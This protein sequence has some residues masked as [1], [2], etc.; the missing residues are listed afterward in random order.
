MAS[1]AGTRASTCTGSP[2]PAQQPVQQQQQQDRRRALRRSRCGSPLT[3]SHRRKRLGCSAWGKQGASAGVQ[4]GQEEQGS[5][6]HEG[7]GTSLPQLGAAHAQFCQLALAQLS[8]CNTNAGK[9]IEA[10]G[11]QHATCQAG[12]PRTPTCQP[13]HAHRLV[14][15]PPAT[16]RRRH[17]A[18]QLPAGLPAPIDVAVAACGAGGW[19]RRTAR[20]LQQRTG[21]DGRC[22]RRGIQTVRQP[23]CYKQ[24]PAPHL[25]G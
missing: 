8:A 5:G 6:G 4:G 14:D 23:R 12:L 7:W 19:G 18:P 2:A 3:G 17:A 21:T 24:Y 25:S 20:R 9:C 15:L 16:R 11:T 13:A 10:R 22:H 1:G